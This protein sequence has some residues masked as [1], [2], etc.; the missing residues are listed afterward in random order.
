[1]SWSWILFILGFGSR[2]LRFNNRFLVYANPA[3]LPFY[4]LHQTIIVGIGFLLAELVLNSYLKYLILV[5]TSFV[6]IM[7]I[8]ELF[9]RRIPLLRYLF[10]MKAKR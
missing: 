10:G 6:V 7:T 5:V 3:V 8:Y 2:Y 9:V 4:I 1:M